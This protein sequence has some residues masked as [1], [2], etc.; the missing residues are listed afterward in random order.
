MRKSILRLALAIILYA[1]ASSALAGPQAIEMEREDSGT[2]VSIDSQDAAM[3]LAIAEARQTL[4]VFWTLFDQYPE[5]S[6]AFGMK[7]G[8]PAKDGELEHIWVYDLQHDGET[9]SGKIANDPY[10]LVGTIKKDDPITFSA[11]QVSDWS[12]WSEGKQYGG[13]TIRV[14]ADALDNATGEEMRA[15]LHDNPIPAFAE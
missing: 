13:F 14:L 7:I 9:Y 5:Y 2:L 4:P 6:E 8:L 10:N 15:S 3:D 12:I 11:S 1:P